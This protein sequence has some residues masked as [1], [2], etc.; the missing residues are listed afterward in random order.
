MSASYGETLDCPKGRNHPKIVCPAG[1]EEWISFARELSE[2]YDWL[3]FEP[4]LS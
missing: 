4:F 3:V 2:E 1:D